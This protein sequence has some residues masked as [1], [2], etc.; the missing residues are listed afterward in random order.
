[1]Q[2]DAESAGLLAQVHDKSELLSH[3]D[4]ASLR[5]RMAEFMRVCGPRPLPAAKSQE[6][7]LRIEG[8]EVAA[9]VHWP[10]AP[11]PAPARMTRPPIVLYFHGG[12][13]THLSATTHDTVARY[14]CNKAGCIVINVDYRLAP[15]HKFPAAIEDGY[16]AL[17][18]AAL[19]ADE[20][21]GDPERIVVAGESAGGTISAILCL[22]AKER[23][24]PR[25]A[26]QVPMCPSMTL[27][28]IQ[29]FASWRTLGTGE[30]LLS[31][32]TIDD[33][34][35]L[36]L[37]GPQDALNPWASPLLAPDLAGLPKALIITAGF[38]PLVDEAAA[39]AQRL[40][41]AG[42]PVTY[43]C[44]PTTLHA[45]M[46]MASLIPVGYVAL[47]LVCRHIASL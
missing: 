21:G 6:R 35:S 17:C 12:G 44:Y 16:D 8:R 4:I 7:R 13:F 42:V 9:I 5:A 19:N 18:W 45:F 22:M 38:D 47:D 32:G 41:E 46:I 43:E 11:S 20:L 34:R 36:Y 10:P 1:M 2:L 3:H 15:E 23:G 25:I 37:R 40:R 29:R 39:Y 27:D 33:I 14:L 30:Y 28:D 26:L 24:G 31:T